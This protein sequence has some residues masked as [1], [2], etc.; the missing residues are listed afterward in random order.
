MLKFNRL[1]LL[2]LLAIWSSTALT[3]FA[4]QIIPT[5]TPI[6]GSTLETIL[7]RGQLTC[8][9]N[10]EIFG[11]GFLNPNTGSISGINVDFCRA[12]AAAIFR[13]ASAIDLRLQTIDTPPDALLSGQLDVLFVQ[14]TIQNLTQD[15]RGGLD[16]GPPM[17]Y[18]GQSIMVTTDSDIKTWEDLDEQ[19]I[20]SLSEGDDAANLA[21]AMSQRGLSYDL[22]TFDKPADMQE[23]FLAGRCNAQ[24]LD[25]SL[26]EIRRQSTDDPS[27]YVVWDAPFTRVAIAPIYRY[28]DQQWSGIVDWTMWGLI[29][30]EEMGITSENIDEYLR[31][32]NETDEIYT[33]RVG[34]PIARLVDPILGLGGQLGLVNDF[35]VEVIRQVGNYGEI[36]DRSL[37]PEST[38][39][40]ERS[41]NALWSDGG[42]IFSPLWR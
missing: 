29:Y 34:L 35:M 21:T 10:Q 4:Q 23:A 25:R 30:A 18:D 31:L 32:A 15:A 11:F 17:F 14:N 9:V 7:T 41:L 5:P 8:G 20:C 1:L 27:A 38:L 24:T 39:P 26:L 22:Q 2:I 42:L 40:I 37:G 13:D 33:N 16:F 28:G 3:A 12:L 19:T 36:Y 6:P